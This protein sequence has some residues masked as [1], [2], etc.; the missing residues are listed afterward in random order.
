[1]GCDSNNWVPWQGAR[2]QINPTMWVLLLNVSTISSMKSL[3]NNLHCIQ[4]TLLKGYCYNAG[5]HI[6]T[7]WMFCWPCIIVYQYSATNVMHFLFSLL[8]T[9]GLYMFR[10]LL[11]HPQEVLHKWHFFFYIYTL[12]YTVCSDAMGNTTYVNAL[13]WPFILQILFLT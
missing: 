7:Y 6:L 3:S 8:R 13:V 1:M 12:Y 11:A 10:A 2:S 9:E 5:N 4:T